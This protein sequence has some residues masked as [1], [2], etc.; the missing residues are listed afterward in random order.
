MQVNA[1]SQLLL[2]KILPEGGN[3]ASRVGALLRLGCGEPSLTAR[4][5]CFISISN[6]QWL[7]HS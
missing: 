5:L 3:G 1:Q 4:L 7:W 2:Q 6:G